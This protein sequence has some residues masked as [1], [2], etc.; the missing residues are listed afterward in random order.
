MAE[1]F[2][3]GV[4]RTADGLNLYVRRDIPHR[5]RGMVVILHSLGE[6]SG[7]YSVI[8]NRVCKA[9]FGV[10]RFDLRGHGRSDGPRGDV[11]DFRD[12]LS[13]TDRI[14][15]Q[16]R[17]D[18]PV[19]PLFLLGH[20]MGALVAVSYALMH[21]DKVDGEVISNAALRRMPALDFLQ[22][23]ARYL[24]GERGDERFSFVVP[25]WQ[26][27]CTAS[28][29]EDERMLDSVTIRLAGNVW[30]QGAGWF[31][32]C[33]GKL[34]TP[35]LILH[36]EEDCLVPLEISQWAY[37]RASSPDKSLRIYAEQGHILLGEE[38][39]VL[40]DIV[41]WLDAR[42]SKEGAVWRLH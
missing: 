1:I 3:V 6:H 15:E 37:E 2:D 20:G 26:E 31:E 11:Q 34:N 22:G 21:P 24:H 32:S 23:D 30:L 7:R 39:D 19:L 33:I 4:L 41:M 29:Q 35:L 16:I 12:Y 17:K 13:D 28:W 10:Y 14:V 9:G 5:P 25:Y 27:G 42:G 38:G 18:F 40:D 36:G 8:A